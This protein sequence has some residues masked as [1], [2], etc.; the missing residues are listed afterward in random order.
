[1]DEQQATVADEPFIC[2]TISWTNCTGIDITEYQ[3]L[4]GV[5][6]DGFARFRISVTL[7]IDGNPACQSMQPIPA[8]TIEEAFMIAPQVIEGA[9]PEMLEAFKAAVRKKQGGKAR[10]ITAAEAR[11]NGS[12]DNRHDRRAQ[13]AAERQRMRFNE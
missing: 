12:Q 9:E 1:M 8:E 4:S 13:E 3:I 2:E 6:P 10:I 7:V 5:P 11:V